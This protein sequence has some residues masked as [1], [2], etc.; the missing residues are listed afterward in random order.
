MEPSVILQVYAMLLLIG[1]PAVATR[2]AARVGDVERAAAF[3]RAIYVSVALSLL[4]IAAVTLGVAWWQEVPGEAL[5]WTVADPGRALAW[6]AAVAAGGLLLAW[7][8]SVVARRLGW[9]EGGIARLLMPRSPQ[10][11]RAFLVLA[12]VGAVCE[13][14][15]YRGFLL[16]VVTA[17]SGSPEAAVAVTALSFGLAHGYQ[18]LPGILRATLLGVLLAVPVVVTGSLFPAV[19]A[20]FWINAAIGL[21]AWRW[22]IADH[23]PGGA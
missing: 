7:I 19:V 10:E 14:Y 18:R 9:G 2:D 3:R 13:E 15:V 4:L 6:A 5:G 22:L 16:W 17:W 8:V 11:K 12:G 20:H 21:G 1:L 23:G